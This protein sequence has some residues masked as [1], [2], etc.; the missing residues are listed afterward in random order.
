MLIALICVYNPAHLNALGSCYVCN[1]TISMTGNIHVV[2]IYRG[3]LRMYETKWKTCCAWICVTILCSLL[4]SGVVVQ[5]CTSCKI[6][7][8]HISHCLFML[9]LTAIFLIT[10]LGNK[11]Q[12]YGLLTQCDFWSLVWAKGDICWPKPRTL[13]EV[14]RW[15]LDAFATVLLDFLRK[16]LSLCLPGCISVCKML[17]C[18]LK[19][20]SK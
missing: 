14:E 17:G 6:D 15:I 11:D 4:P 2:I 16:I 5:S 12:Q 1:R 13:D 10:G 18:V 9:A 8:Y 3:D 7:H 20:D 19:F